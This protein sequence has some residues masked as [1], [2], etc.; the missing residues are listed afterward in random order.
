MDEALKR[1]MALVPFNATFHGEHRDPQMLGKLTAEGPAVLAW[2]IQGAADWLERGIELPAAVRT[3]SDEYAA[4]MDALG[5]WIADKCERDLDGSEAAGLLYRSYADWK[6]D[7]GENPVSPTRWSEQLV[8]RGFERYRND[9]SRF[10]G[11]AST[12][13]SAIELRLETDHE[14]TQRTPTDTFP[15][16]SY[17]ARAHARDRGN[18]ARVSVPVRLSVRP[19][20]ALDS[21]S[22]AAAAPTRS[23]TSR[24]AVN[25]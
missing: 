13:T 25:D 20:P 10:A 18:T 21:A 8:S 17:R 2:M 3:A 11:F 15:T 22:R 7:R 14:Q 6:R 24:E 23:P 9:G 19:A 4:T 5:N 1:R 16:Y 12:R